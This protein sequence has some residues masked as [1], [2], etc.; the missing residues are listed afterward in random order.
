MKPRHSAPG[1]R[2]SASVIWRPARI[3]IR[4]SIGAAI[5]DGR[6]FVLERLQAQSSQSPVV[7][8]PAGLIRVDTVVERELTS[9]GPVPVLTKDDFAIQVDGQPHPVAYFLADPAPLSIALL[10]DVSDSLT[11]SSSPREF[12]LALDDFLAFGVGPMDRARIGADR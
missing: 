8:F 6:G 4:R 5:V 3:V 11:L 10:V 7:Q 1:I 2:H 12:R 9:T